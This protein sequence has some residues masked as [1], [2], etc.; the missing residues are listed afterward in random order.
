MIKTKTLILVLVSTLTL[1]LSTKESNSH[2]TLSSKLQQ[3]ISYNSPAAR[4]REQQLEHGWDQV[5]WP[6]KLQYDHG[7]KKESDHYTNKKGIETFTAQRDGG[8]FKPGS[9][10]N[11]RSERRIEN[12]YDS[13][14]QP[15]Q[16]SADFRVPKGTDSV[17]IM[18]IFGGNRSYNKKNPH[19]TSFMFQVHNNDLTYY[20]NRILAKDI[21]G[22]W[23]HMN[24]IHDP[25][26][27]QIQAYLN[28]QEVW[29]GRDKGHDVHFIKYGA[30]GQGGIEDM[31]PTMRSQFKNVKYFVKPRR[32]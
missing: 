32:R 11:S 16:F 21:T 17:A 13:S 23:E 14:H 8:P 1:T 4:Q 2:P 19:S 22:K 5:H 18:Q 25:K 7:S 27:H 15:Q 6:S 12:D 24:V 30:Y 20:K 29:H 26:S 3:Q 10:T 28:G 9:K 31:S